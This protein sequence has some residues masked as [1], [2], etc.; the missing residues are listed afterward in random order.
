MKGDIGLGRKGAAALRYGALGIPVFP[1]HFI[2]QAL[3]CS[4]RTGQCCSAGKHPLG[5][6]VPNGLKDASRDEETIRTWW[7]KEPNANIG[8][9]MGGRF[10]GL[11]IDPRHGGAEGVGWLEQAFG[12]LPPT[13][14]QQTG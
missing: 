9:R 11:D 14:T 10:L 4:C 12:P 7:T 8:G 3:R 2:T 6:L 1:C 5:K 13:P